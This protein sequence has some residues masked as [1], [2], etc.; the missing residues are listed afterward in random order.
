MLNKYSLFSPPTV[1]AKL[2]IYLMLVRLMLE[3]L[4][5]HVYFLPFIAHPM[6][7]SE[8][9][10]P[11]QCPVPSF[12]SQYNTKLRAFRAHTIRSSE[13]FESIQCQVPS[14]SSHYNSRLRAFRA[15]TMQSFELFEP[16]KFQA[17]SFLSPHNAKL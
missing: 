3:F 11:I 13:L 17:P 10:E 2:L 4:L 9:F 14:F 7:S 12:S 5:Q 15:N 8:L 16:I 6:P 1:S